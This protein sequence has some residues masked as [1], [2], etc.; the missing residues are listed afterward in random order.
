MMFNNSKTQCIEKDLIL[1]SVL[2]TKL[3][4]FNQAC[5]DWLVSQVNFEIIDVIPLAGA[6]GFRRYYRVVGQN[7][8]L[9]MVDASQSHENC[10]AFV[11]IANALRLL[12]VKTPKILGCDFKQR[13]LLLSDFGDTTYLHALNANPGS[14]D[15][16]YLPALQ[17]LARMQNCASPID[18]KIPDFTPDF[19]LR[20]WAWHKEWFAEKW[21]NLTISPSLQK[22][23]DETM[24]QI[25]HH[26]HSQPQTFM[27]RDYHSTNLMVLPQNEVG[28]LDFQ[29]AFVGPITYDVVSLLRDCYLDWSPAEVTR[30][31]LYYKNQVLSAWSDEEFLFA[32]DMMSVQ[33]H[34]KALLTFARKKV[35]DNDKHYLKYIP[36]TIYYLHSITKQHSRL[37]AIYLYLQDFV[38][39][40]LNRENILCEP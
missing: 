10:Y 6:A 21:L 31:A 34:L 5:K 36:R 2:E 11:A 38:M 24:M 25:I 37:N 13:F 7:N 30:W 3:S 32:M 18:Y 12:K 29:D 35:R 16:L 8:S 27:H 39:P 4:N 14:A 9:I 33:R 17:T 20:E 19:M 26:V 40:A 15:L 22:I 23:L 28:V 1:E